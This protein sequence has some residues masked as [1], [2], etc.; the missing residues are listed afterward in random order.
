MSTR[1]LLEELAGLG[2]SLWVEGD[3][4]RCRGS[5]KIVTPEL[6]AQIKEHKSEILK[7]LRPDPPPTTPQGLDTSEAKE[8]YCHHGTP[9]RCW[10]CKKYGLKPQIQ[11]TVKEV[12]ENPP[13][14]I[15]EA[16]LPGY[17][18]GNI[19]L[20]VLAGAVAAEMGHSPYEWADK[21]KPEVKAAVSDLLGEQGRSTEMVRNH[22]GGGMN[23]E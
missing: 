18:R 22:P 20:D 13:Y 14:W 21:L 17:R 12:L 16:Y 11:K 9:G 19:S 7:H 8:R 5:K 2:V 3:E 23:R 4:L 15:R 1:T 10:L 6:L